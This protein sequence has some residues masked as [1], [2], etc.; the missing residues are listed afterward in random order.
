MVALVVRYFVV[1]VAIKIAP[2]SLEIPAIYKNMY[3]SG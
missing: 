1:M 3:S 2:D